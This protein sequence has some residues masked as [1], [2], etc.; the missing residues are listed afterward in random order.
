MIPICIFPGLIILCLT[1]FTPREPAGLCGY[2]TGG[3][4]NPHNRSVFTSGTDGAL[5]HQEHPRP[6]SHHSS[7]REAG[8]S[9]WEPLRHPPLPRKESGRDASEGPQTGLRTGGRSLQHSQTRWLPSGRCLQTVYFGRKDSALSAR[10]RVFCSPELPG[11]VPGS[12]VI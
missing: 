6:S 11:R 8:V 12:R 1:F 2:V 5:C 3:L 10:G 7:P 9:A 4:R